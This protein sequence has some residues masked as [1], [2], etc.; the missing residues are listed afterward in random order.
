MVEER[1]VEVVSSQ[2]LSLRPTRDLTG[3]KKQFQNTLIPLQHLPCCHHVTELL[4]N[5]PDF[6]PNSTN[7]PVRGQLKEVECLDS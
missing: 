5:W 6:L 4:R 2:R 3:T 7:L 1:C